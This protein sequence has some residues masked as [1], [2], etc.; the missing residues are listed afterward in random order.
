VAY[1]VKYAGLKLDFCDVSINDACLSADALESAIKH[2]PSIKVVIGVHLYGNVL[3]MDSI[4]K[5]CKKYGIVFIEDVCQA[6]GSYYKDRPC[7]SFGDYSILSFGHTKILDAGHGGTLLTDDPNAAEIIRNELGN[8]SR[9]NRREHD[10]L[11]KNHTDQYY[12]LQAL[13]RNNSKKIVLFEKLLKGFLGNF[14]HGI[15]DSSLKRLK[16]LLKKEEKIIAHR[17]KLYELYKTALRNNSNIRF[18]GSGHKI[19]PWRFS[20]LMPHV[21]TLSLCDVLRNEGFDIS[22]WYPNLAN[23]F[24]SDN[25]RKLKKANFIENSV[26]NLWVDESKDVQDVSDICSRLME[27]S[28]NQQLLNNGKGKI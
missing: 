25:K 13:S 9:Y 17:I 18:V 7:G 23:M 12:K 26:V 10:R 21:D 11:S 22:T 16:G 6:Y 27:L 24:V 3:D 1:A 2:N 19:V 8:L 28:S 20:F 4:V 14:V 5:I 15:D